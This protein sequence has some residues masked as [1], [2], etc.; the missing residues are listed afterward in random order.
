MVVATLLH[1]CGGDARPS[2]KVTCV[3]AVAHAVELMFASKR[4]TSEGRESFDKNKAAIL[5]EAT[6]TCEAMK[7]TQDDLQCVMRTAKNSDM[8]GCRLI[9]DTQD[10]PYEPPPPGTSSCA[11]VGRR[12]VYIL[13][14]RHGDQAPPLLMRAMMRASMRDEATKI[15]SDCEKEQWGP[16]KRDCVMGAREMGAVLQCQIER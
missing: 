2:E 14:E 12:Y 4:A 9:T 13:S 15:E 6:T 3:Q 11:A 16:K 7:L 1:G 10:L 8:A 5:K